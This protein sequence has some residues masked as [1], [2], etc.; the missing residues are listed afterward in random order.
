MQVAS[1]AYLDDSRDG[2]YLEATVHNYL[3]CVSGPLLCVH[4]RFDIGVQSIPVSETSVVLAGRDLERFKF[5]SEGATLSP[6]KT[7]LKLFCP[8]CTF[9]G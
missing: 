4:S 7:D 8:V 6:G 3:P 5:T 2:S 1:S 9:V